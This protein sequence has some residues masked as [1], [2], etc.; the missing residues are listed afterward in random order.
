MAKQ[1]KVIRHAS[2]RGFSGL[3][4]TLV[5]VPPIAAVFGMSLFRIE[6]LRD[7]PDRYVAL[8][9]LHRLLGDSNFTASIPRTMLFALGTT[10]LTVPIALATALLMNKAKGRYSAVLSVAGQQMADIGI[11][12]AFY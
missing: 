6:L 1:Q 9:N 4:I 3:L 8:K 5:A 7:G 10:V 2:G 11:S 12:C